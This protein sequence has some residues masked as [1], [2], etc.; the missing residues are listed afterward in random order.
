MIVSFLCSLSRLNSRLR[1]KLAGESS[2]PN[3]YYVCYNKFSAECFSYNLVKY[4]AQCAI[5]NRLHSKVNCRVDTRRL[6]S[7]CGAGNHHLLAVNLFISLTTACLTMSTMVYMKRPLSNVHNCKYSSCNFNVAA[8]AIA[9]D[10][11]GCA[12]ASSKYC[13][14]FLLW[15]LLLNNYSAFSQGRG[16]VAVNRST[17]LVT[18]IHGHESAGHESMDRQSAVDSSIAM[19]GKETCYHPSGIEI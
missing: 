13:C 2:R 14:L 17:V 5:T 18:R 9:T 8:L 7:L 10:I 15:L 16:T 6:D 3:K 11:V 1:L 19:S 4:A 12:W